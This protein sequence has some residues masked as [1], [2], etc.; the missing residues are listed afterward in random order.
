MLFSVIIPVFNGDRY[1]KDCLDSLLRQ[2]FNDYEVIV[3][4]DGSSDKSGIIADAFASAN[5]NINVIHCSN[6]GPYLARRLAISHANGEYAVFLD[7]DDGLREDALEIIS[8]CI[9]ETSADII[10]FRYSSNIDFSTKDD[11][12]FLQPGLYVSSKFDLFKEAVCLGRSNSLWGKAIRIDC[13]DIDDDH[14]IYEHFLMAEDLFQLIPIVDRARSLLRLN[15]SLYYY[16]PNDSGSTST[17]KHTYISD[18]ARVA[19]R[20]L[21]YGDRWGMKECAV[22]GALRLYV[23]LT[24]LLVD[25]ISTLG[26][27]CANEEFKLERV[28]LTELSPNIMTDIKHLRLDY[29]LLLTAVLLGNFNLVRF[30]TW[31]SHK[32]RMFLSLCEKISN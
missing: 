6:R 11:E 16:R 3:V 22:T 9:D 8:H 26:I 28:S 12:S 1:L 13:I 27:D 21:V 5:N 15:D 30:I 18:T 20:L 17:Y 24:K 29:R 19:D 32:Y 23:N 7:A 4:D 14:D 25:S 31:L 2:T 10:S